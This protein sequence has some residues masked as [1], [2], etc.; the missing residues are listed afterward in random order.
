MT[1]ARKD[2]TGKYAFQVT[3]QGATTKGNVAAQ[4]TTLVLGEGTEIV[5]LSANVEVWY[6]TSTGTA[7]AVNDGTNTTLLPAG[8]IEY[9]AVTPGETMGWVAGTATAT[10][11]LS[12]EQSQ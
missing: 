6:M 8:Q 3:H 5:R 1:L 12:I 9:R 7:T 2:G 11:Y 4:A 10:G